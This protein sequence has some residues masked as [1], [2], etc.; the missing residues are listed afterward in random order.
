MQIDRIG[1]FTVLCPLGR[2]AGSQVFRV[3]RE[4]DGREY[5]LK[6]VSEANGAKGRFLNQL[7]REFRVGRRLD[8]P[9]LEQV[10]ALE[11]ESDW[12]FRP[13]RGKLLLEFIPG[14][15]LSQVAALPPASIA[16]LF[17][18]VAD[19]LAHMH[20]AGVCHSDLKPENLM[21]RPDGV[22]KVIDF[23]LAR[24]TGETP[25]RFQGT[26]EY[27]APETRASKVV[28]PAT[29][30]FNFGATLYRL[31][32]HRFL[33]ASPAGLAVDRRTYARSLVPV[34]TLNPAAPDGLCDVVHWCVSFD[35]AE[36]PH[37]MADVATALREGAGR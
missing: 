29:D 21:L 35:P 8:H 22:V 18:C 20:A 27:M 15:P 10:H 23:G 7:R 13:K 14:R 5:A 37:D 34:A 19:A 31:L 24:A 1:P 26:P 32:T 33:P 2:G 30:A 3:R 6:V 16:S 11:V 12:L 25:D 17:A 4:R 36:R 9:N 28:T